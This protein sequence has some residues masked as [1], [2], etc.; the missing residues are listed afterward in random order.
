MQ[1]IGT[2]E[3]MSFFYDWW[4][5]INAALEDSI[6]KCDQ[7]LV[8]HRSHFHSV[9]QSTGRDVANHRKHSAISP[10]IFGIS[11][12][13]KIRKSKSWIFFYTNIYQKTSYTHHPILHKITK[14]LLSKNPLQ[15][16]KACFLFMK[17]RNET[18]PPL[19]KHGQKGLVFAFRSFFSPFLFFYY[20]R[21]FNR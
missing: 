17:Y 13:L 7:P 4:I 5:S 2:C 19:S 12:F 1:R 21:D 9:T 11:H 3:E 15:L 8:W 6:V 10:Y 14:N 18:Y 20:N 16:I